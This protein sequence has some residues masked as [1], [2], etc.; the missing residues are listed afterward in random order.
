MSCRNAKDNQQK[1]T[2]TSKQK[3][4]KISNNCK[5]N[6]FVMF[7]YNQKNTA[8][9]VK[10]AV[11]WSEFDKHHLR[12]EILAKVEIVRQQ[13]ANKQNSKDEACGEKE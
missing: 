13:Y 9:S 1:L 12:E 7:L 5:F 6:K 11:D 8:K 4:Q 3:I 10:S 2:S